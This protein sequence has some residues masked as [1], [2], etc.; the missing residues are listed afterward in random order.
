MA[1][2]NCQR[3]FAGTSQANYNYITEDILSSIKT[4]KLSKLLCFINEI[5]R[6]EKPPQQWKDGIIVKLPK[7][8]DLSDCNNWRGITLLS[9]PGKILCSMMLERLKGQVDDKIREEQAGFRPKRSCIDQIFTLRT[10]IEESVEM[11]SPLIINFIDFQKAFDSLHRPTLWNILT[12]YGFPT[13]YLNIIKAL[14]DNSRCCVRTNEG[15]TEWFHIETG[16]KQGCIMSPLLF[17]IAID[18]V[19][20]NYAQN[21]HFGINW[22]DDKTLEDLDFADDLAFLST[23]PDKAQE[24]INR[25]CRLSEQVGLQVNT[26]KTKIINF[27]NSNFDIVLNGEMLQ[28]VDSFSYLG[29]R[30]TQD[31]DTTKEISTRIALAANVF[32]NLTNIWKSKR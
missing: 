5:W 12:S 25:L 22:T 16:V 8:G 28:K 20:K 21:E 32:N 4:I 13:K 26:S 11:Q 6:E 29:S 31:G 14:Y 30:M 18:W 27:T 10:I 24:M 7:K 17:G 9:V 19:M 1:M 23:T 3:F 15:K 2:F